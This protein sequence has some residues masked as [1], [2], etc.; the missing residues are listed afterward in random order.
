MTISENGAEP[1][2]DFSA[3][4]AKECLL[5]LSQ[6]RKFFPQIPEYECVCARVRACQCSDK[7]PWSERRGGGSGSPRQGFVSGHLTN[8]VLLLFWSRTLRGTAGRISPDHQHPG[9]AARCHFCALQPNRDRD[10]ASR[11]QAAGLASDSG[12]I[13]SHMS[14]ETRWICGQKCRRLGVHLLG[15]LLWSQI[16]R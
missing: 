2:G 12:E 7:Q 8:Q 14:A 15:S 13:L 5:E 9:G 16:G 3:A 10:R 6:R 11:V 1:P 4:P